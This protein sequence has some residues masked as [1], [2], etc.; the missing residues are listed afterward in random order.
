MI[1]QKIPFKQN[2]LGLNSFMANLLKVTIPVCLL[3]A[4]S[5]SHSDNN[6]PITTPTQNLQ[7][8]SKKQIGLLLPLTGRNG[9]LGN[10]ML[11][12]ARLAIDEPSAL[13]VHDTAETGGASA[14]AHKA[15][16]AGDG[17]IL[18][19]LTAK[20]T[21]EVAAVTGA[22]NIP[23]L[24]Y[25]SNASI[26]SSNVWIFGITQNQQIETL[27]KAAKNEGRMKFAAFLPDNSFGRAMADGLIKSCSDQGL[28]QPTIVYHAADLSDITQKLKSM[29]N[30][31]ERT[32][33]AKINSQNQNSTDTTAANGPKEDG[34]S[35]QNELIPSKPEKK[36]ETKKLKLDKPPFDALLLADT[37]L[38][39]QSVINAMNEVQVSTSQ[40]RI[41]GPT[42]WSSFVGKLGKLK[43]A[44]YVAPNPVKRQEFIRQYMARYGQTPKPLADF[45]YDSAALA[46]SLRKRP[47]G[48]SIE[49]L[50]RPD[51]FNGIDGFFALHPDG[52]VKRDLQ[53]FEIQSFGGGKMISTPK[54]NTSGSMTH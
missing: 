8:P 19:P 53:I 13:D 43:G 4:C 25:S 5:S 9:G 29:S 17:I 18:G 10:N 38:Q 44:W 39:L 50:T 54:D 35:L 41:M 42:L 28:M 40:V 51:G 26:A 46:N 6:T 24:S 33:A 52:T 22:V 12:A 14:A 16:E 45:T 21:T 31:D 1:E 47:G 48:F 2:C 23:V 11:K 7:Q 3:A 36:V 20:D 32:E 27:V 34:D 30:F 15:I 37:G 49:N